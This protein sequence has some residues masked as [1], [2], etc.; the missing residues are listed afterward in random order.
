MD[1]QHR[2]LR[3][4]AR[5]IRRARGGGYS[6]EIFSHGRNY[7]CRTFDTLDEAVQERDAACDVLGLG[8][9]R[10][11]GTPIPAPDFDT[12][13]A[14]NYQYDPASGIVTR[15]GH[16]IGNKDADGYVTMN[17]RNG[18]FRRNVKAHRFAFLVMTGT[19]PRFTV[20]HINGVR[21]DNRWCN[22]R[23]VTIQENRRNQTAIPRGREIVW[24]EG[25]YYRLVPVE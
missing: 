10:S 12:F 15:G 3:R 22:L 6:V 25:R 21:T 19:W 2:P 1:R 18:A 11:F 8:R 14:R 23:D 4:V 13:L 24:H 16:A 5:Y 7:F 9:Q 17:V 20:D